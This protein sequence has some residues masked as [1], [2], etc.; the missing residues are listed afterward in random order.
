MF[1]EASKGNEFSAK[2]IKLTHVV[3]KGG[4]EHEAA[5]RG[6]RAVGDAE[7]LGRALREYHCAAYN[8]LINLF[9]TTQ[10]KEKNTQAILDKYCYRQGGGLA[11]MQT[12]NDS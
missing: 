3:R 10:R 11:G 5:L 12:G 9:L 7:L 4:Y 8:L 1:G 2:Y 6:S